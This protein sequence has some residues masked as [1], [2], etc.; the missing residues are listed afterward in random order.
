M[1]RKKAGLGTLSLLGNKERKKLRE[2]ALRALPLL[3]EADFDLLLPPKDEISVAKLQFPPAS[4]GPASGAATGPSL[5]NSRGS[6]RGTVYLCRGEPIFFEVNGVIL[7]SVYALWQCPEMLP[8]FVVHAP[9]SSFILKGAD[10]MLPGI[11]WTLTLQ[12]LETQKA[13]KA[14]NPDGRSLPPGIEAMQVWSV[15][16]AGNPAVSA[17]SLQHLA[18]KGKALEMVHAYGDGLWQIGSQSSPN[19]LFTA[20]QVLGDPHHAETAVSLASVGAAPS[21]ARPPEGK[22]AS[23]FPDDDGWDSNPEDGEKREATDAGEEEGKTGVGEPG[24]PSEPGTDEEEGREGEGEEGRGEE[25]ERDEASTQALAHT[26]RQPAASAPTLPTEKK[27]KIVLPE[28][29]ALPFKF[30][31]D[32]ACP[33]AG[34]CL[35]LRVPKRKQRHDGDFSAWAATDVRGTSEAVAF[36]MQVMDEYLRLCALEVLHAISDEQLPMDISA[37]NRQETQRNTRQK[38]RRTETQ[39]KK[40][41]HTERAV[42]PGK[43]LEAEKGEADAKKKSC[44]IAAEAPAVYVEKLR[45]AEKPSTFVAP[46]VRK[47]SHKKLVKFVQS[48]SKKKLLQTKETRGAVAMVKVNRSHPQYV[49]YKPIPEKTK[50]RILERFAAEETG[51]AS[52]SVAAGNGPGGSCVEEPGDRRQPGRVSAGGGAAAGGNAVAGGD[53]GPLVLEFCTP[54]QKLSK[55]FTAMQVQTGKDTFFTFAEAKEVLTRYLEAAQE[56]KKE[57]AHASD[58]SEEKGRRKELRSDEVVVDG[59]LKDALLTKE[60]LASAKDSAEMKMKKEEVFTRW[61]AAL[62][63]CYVMVPPGA[64][65]DL[66]VSTLK[67]HKGAWVPVRISVEDR[68]GGRKHVTHVVGVHAFL[69]EPKTVAEYLQKKLAAAAS[70]YALPGQKEQNAI[71]I[72]GN[73]ASAVAE[74][75]VAHFKLD[76]KYLV[77]EQKKPKSGSSRK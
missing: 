48:L 14:E 17:A 47:T 21:A 23:A 73:M 19:S 63:P 57:G 39:R 62:Q 3:V 65:R 12:G 69:L 77:I 10:L 26:D 54:P 37:L 61:L 46:D 45:A 50:K 72:Q 18:G 74:A 32:C 28:R 42:Y 53:S 35:V 20:K 34:S 43:V 68:F 66:D 59:V 76:R 44:K 51:G 7:P 71:A 33:V 75:L 27:R 11:I 30:M 41:R 52:P 40:W 16:V 60:E 5:T 22:A 58:K 8:T 2:Q 55:V 67:V 6:N 64:P 15:R 31:R 56:A 36:R 4:S 1:F 70:T 38:G 29:R 13:E 24:P 49:E 9:V 25:D